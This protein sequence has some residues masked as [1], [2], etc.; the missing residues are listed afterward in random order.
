[1]RSQAKKG[2]H[3]VEEAAGAGGEWGVD[4]V[5]QRPREERA[6]PS[7]EGAHGGQ[8]VPVHKTLAEH[9]VQQAD[10]GSPRLLDGALPA[11]EAKGAQMGHAPKS[12]IRDVEEFPTP[13]R[14]VEAIAGPVPCDAKRRRL[15]TVFRHTREDVRVVVLDADD[16]D[17]GRGRIPGG[18]IVGVR[19]TGDA[20]RR[21]IVQLT[22]IGS[23][24]AEG[25]EG[26]CRSPGRRCAG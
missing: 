14:P 9:L 15:K 21:E 23:H 20:R 18:G 19:I 26:L 2:R 10:G 13:D 17:A 6:V 12:G 3:R 22:E 1:M 16:R 25:I 4:A 5:G 11:G 7:V 24:A 8:I